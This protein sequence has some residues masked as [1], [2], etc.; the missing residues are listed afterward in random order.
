MFHI[1]V[2]AI[3]AA[4]LWLVTPAAAEETDDRVALMFVACPQDDPEL[5][6]A[7]VEPFRSDYQVVTVNLGTPGEEPNEKLLVGDLGH[8][9]GHAGL[10]R[11]VL[12]AHGW[13]TRI[14]HET[15]TRNRD[16]VID[17]LSVGSFRGSPMQADPEIYNELLRERLDS[18]LRPPTEALPEDTPNGPVPPPTA[19]EISHPTLLDA[20]VGSNAS[21]KR[22][23]A[24]ST[25]PIPP[26]VHIRMNVHPDGRVSDVNIVDEQVRT[27]EVGDCLRHEIGR[28][29][30]PAFEG[31]T[32][33][34]EAS[35]SAP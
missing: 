35:L 19:A 6:A 30:F 29:M 11:I 28:I 27:A 3:C 2:F 10:E 12:V 17:A 9:L 22:C 32:T 31:E 16:T 33:L 34:V 23:L 24:A 21:A 20:I 4:T 1:R 7:Q 18:L 13:C 5:W 25:I 8:I 15:A 26:D 14:T